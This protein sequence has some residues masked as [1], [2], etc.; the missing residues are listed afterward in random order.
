MSPRG[1]TGSQAPYDGCL[2]QRRGLAGR[3]PLPN[4]LDNGEA[5]AIKLFLI[6]VL[7]PRETGSAL[8]EGLTVDGEDILGGLLESARTV[9]LL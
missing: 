6:R 2:L 3:I 4:G 5:T 9:T 1:H 8:G 7:P